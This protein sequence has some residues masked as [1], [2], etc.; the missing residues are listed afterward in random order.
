MLELGDLRFAHHGREPVVDGF[1]LAV[2]AGET[3][4][5]EGPSGSGKST[6]LRIAAG[7]IPRI[8]GG[9]IA[10]Q[11][12]LGGR[13]VRQIPPAEMPETIGWVPQD[14]E[15]SFAA[16]TVDRELAQLARNLDLADPRAAID[17]AL[18]VLDAAHLVDREIEQLSGGEAARVSLAAAGLGSPQALV[19]DEPTAQLDSEGRKRARAWID[20]HRARG[21]SVLAAEHAPHPLDPDRV[22]RLGAGAEPDP[23]TWLPEAPR[24]PAQARLDGATACFDDARVGPLDLAVHPGEVV[25]LTGPNGAGKTTALHLLCGLEEPDRGQ[26]RLGEHRPAD[27]SAEQLARSVGIAFQHPAWHITQDTVRQEVALTA[28]TLEIALAPQE[29]LT[30][31]GLAGYAEEHPW[32]LSGGERQRLAVAT[33]SAHDPPVLLLDEP[34]RGLD[35]ASLGDLAD[36]LAARVEA[37]AA[38]IVASHH[39]WMHELAH[40]TVP[41][42]GGSA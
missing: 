9:R 29:K 36:L 3:H 32:D 23:A 12:R 2:P 10:G 5:L 18:A 26:A 21:A 4:L 34:T 35:R 28:D 33:A 6:L 41:L 8:Q 16:R 30:R 19:L 22:H 27:L 25:C 15:E 38:T 14:P 37:G 20:D 31:L 1:D 24:G 7:L 13:P 40:R 11:A 42:E 39:S 17:R